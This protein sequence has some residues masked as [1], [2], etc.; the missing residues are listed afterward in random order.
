[1]KM[2][3]Q[4]TTFK[5][6]DWILMRPDFIK[7][8]MLEYVR[9]NL[10]KRF[11]KPQQIIDIR[12]NTLQRTVYKFSPYNSTANIAGFRMATESE[13]KAQQIKEIFLK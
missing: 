8:M 9:N 12:I 1:M 13:I 3:E 7:G 2:P 6:G 11:S 10:T 5:V 4:E